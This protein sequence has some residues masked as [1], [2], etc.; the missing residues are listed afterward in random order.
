MLHEHAGSGDGIAFSTNY[1]AGLG[2]LN[3]RMLLAA[4]IDN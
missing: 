1:S 3:E 2:A 4:D